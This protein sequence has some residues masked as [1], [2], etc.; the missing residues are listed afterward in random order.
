MILASD[1]SSVNISHRVTHNQKFNRSYAFPASLHMNP[2][3]PSSENM[4]RPFI[5]S[6]LPFWFQA[7]GDV[8]ERMGECRCLSFLAKLVGVVYTVQGAGGKT[9]FIDNMAA[10]YL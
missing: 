7:T 2:D 5:Y 4:A 1:L 9:A 10:I 8:F 3:H 6:K